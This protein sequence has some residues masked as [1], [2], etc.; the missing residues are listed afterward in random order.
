MARRGLSMVSTIRSSGAKSEAGLIS[1][2]QRNLYGTTDIGGDLNCNS[3]AGCGTIFELSKT[4]TETVLYTFKGGH[5]GERPLAALLRDAAGNLYGT[6]WEGG[7]D[8]CGGPGCGTVFKL[9][10]VSGVETILHRFTG[11]TDG[12]S[13]VSGLIS[14]A[15]GNLYGATELSGDGNGVCGS[16]GCGTVFKIDTT[17]K[18]TILY[19]FTG[20]SDGSE[21]SG[22]LVRDV[23]GNL[24]GTTGLGGDLTCNAPCG[25]GMV[26]K[27]DRAGTETVH[28]AFT[29]S[30]ADGNNPIAGVILDSS[31]N[32]YGTT[33][34]DGAFGFGTIFKVNAAGNETILYNFTGNQMAAFPT[35]D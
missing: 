29:G 1:D 10:P 8:G 35:R 3:G 19:R 15:Q 16:L 23:S 11:G 22:T 30:P 5:D 32:L 6:T 25:C 13:P 21:P 28:H 12:Q 24:Y 9:E 27:L 33:Y 26:F 17:G 34:R 4:G 2:S 14:D 31:G 20:G 18:E 7:G